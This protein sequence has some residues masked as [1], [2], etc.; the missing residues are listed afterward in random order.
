MDYEVG[1]LSFFR[2]KSQGG[3]KEITLPSQSFDDTLTLKTN[4]FG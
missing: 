1:H 3:N 2:S 4:L